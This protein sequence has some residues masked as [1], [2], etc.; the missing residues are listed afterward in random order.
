MDIRRVLTPTRIYTVAFVGSLLILFVIGT[1]ALRQIY[2]LGKSQES[3]TNSH[4]IRIDLERLFSELKDAETAERGFIIT[5]DSAYLKPSHYAHVRINKSLIALRELTQQNSF[6]QNHIDELTLLVNKRFRMLRDN[7]IAVNKMSANSDF[8]RELMIQE[9]Q[10]MNQIRRL[11]D[12]IILRESKILQRQE[13]NYGKEIFFTPIT[14]IILVVF[15]LIIFLLTFLHITQNLRKLKKLNHSLKMTNDVFKDAERIGEI[16]HWQLDLTDQKLWLS[17]NKY[18]LLGCDKKSFKPTLDK[19]LTLVHPSDRK[20]VRDSFSKIARGQTHTV[21]YR[22]RRPDRKVRYIKTISKI[23][24]DND[25]REIIIGVDVDITSQ[26]KNTIKLERRN[27]QLKS[28]NDELT[29]FNHIVSHDLQE[30]LRK[31]QMFISRIDE[32]EI[33]QL[34][35]E[36]QKYISRI[37]S[38]AQ[39]A[40]QLISDLLIYSRLSRSQSQ[41]E[42]TDL[43]ELLAS[44]KAELRNKLDQVNA[45]IK[46]DALPTI[47]VM[48]TQISQLFTNLIT[49][50]IKYH[51]NTL[52][53]EIAI[54]YRVVS[55]KTISEIKLPPNRQFH[56]ITFSDNGIGF[57]SAYAERIFEIFHRLHDNEKYSGTGIGLAICKKIAHN[58]SGYI[59]AT[60]GEHGAIFTLLL[61]IKP[62]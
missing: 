44:V 18:Q 59:F 53:V 34:T 15:S 61:P 7:V 42:V 47:K 46:S 20:K 17:D 26:H 36:T 58:H 12:E 33:S 60:S 50:A 43:N 14:A 9:N 3:V 31:I 30:P 1:I 4:K 32:S 13:E 39:R 57:D 51:C 21:Y 23:N 41:P 56:Y 37:Q 29:S 38:S 27:L 10:L 5:K 48:P 6:R 2:A 49:N 45:M 52:P 62:K 40:Q 28:S 16:S 55:S 22:I 19:F 24:L 11:V 54:S 8:F 35:Q 25:G